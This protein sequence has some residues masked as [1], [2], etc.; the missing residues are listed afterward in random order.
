[1]RVMPGPK[2]QLFEVRHRDWRVE[3]VRN[4]RGGWT[5]TWRYPYALDEVNVRDESDAV[6]TRRFNNGGWAL[7]VDPR[8]MLH[9]GI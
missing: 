6:V 9:E 3:C 5:V 2:A 8:V 4:P 1:M 7:D